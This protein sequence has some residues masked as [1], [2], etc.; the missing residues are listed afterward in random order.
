VAQYLGKKKG[1][2][3]LYEAKRL[4]GGPTG[5]GRGKHGALKISRVKLPLR[6]KGADKWGE[7]LK[8]VP[9][10]KEKEKTAIQKPGYAK[11]AVTEARG[12]LKRKMSPKK[13]E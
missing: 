13:K 3:V 11:S 5:L 7:V 1:G 6:T 2:I 8:N 10:G 4:Q 9:G 12:Y